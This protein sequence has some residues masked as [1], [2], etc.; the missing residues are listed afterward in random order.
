MRANNQVAIGRRDIN[1]AG[2]NGFSVIGTDN[3]HRAAVLEHIGQKLALLA[4]MDYG[5]NG[6]VESGGYSGAGPAGHGCF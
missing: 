5:Q 3:G 1:S 4:G 2:G 6:S